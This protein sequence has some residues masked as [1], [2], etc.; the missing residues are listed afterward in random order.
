MPDDLYMM[1]VIRS[2][3]TLSVE[4]KESKCT[5]KGTF[6]SCHHSA[7][8]E[9]SANLQIEDKSWWVEKYLPFL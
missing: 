9:K 1:Y 6:I 3:H 2:E 4:M 8:D 7:D 5:C